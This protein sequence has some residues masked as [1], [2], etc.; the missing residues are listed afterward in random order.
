MTGPECDA[1]A[2]SYAEGV[3]DGRKHETEWVALITVDRDEWKKRAKKAE[4]VMEQMAEAQERI[5]Y[6][7][8]TIHAGVPT[9]ETIRERAAAALSAAR[10]LLEVT[11]E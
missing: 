3:R 9:L 2:A 1:M 10:E 7:T 5:I 4:E 8:T 6:L 11:H